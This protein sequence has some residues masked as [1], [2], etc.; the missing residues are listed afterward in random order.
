MRLRKEKIEKYNK[1]KESRVTFESAAEI[2]DISTASLAHQTEKRAIR[3]I[4][5]GLIDRGVD[6][7]EAILYVQ[8]WL[9][10]KNPKTILKCL[11]KEKVEIIG[12]K[13]QNMMNSKI[14]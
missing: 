1:H 3:K 9:G 2:L 12:Q 13:L 8:Q 5:Q 11:P 4:V 14:V 10:I 7:I 6:D